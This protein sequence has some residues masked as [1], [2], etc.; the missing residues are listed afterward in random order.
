[1]LRPRRRRSLA[2]G[3]RSAWERH[4]TVGGPL[5]ERSRRPEG[6][7]LSVVGPNEQ[8]AT[9]CDHAR[10]IDVATRLEL[11]EER[12]RVC[13]RIDVVVLRPEIEPALRVFHGTAMNAKFRCARSSYRK[14]KPQVAVFGVERHEAR[15]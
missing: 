10:G 2:S 7:K 5:H 3:M 4:D 11:P 13:Q 14:L 8:E 12:A 9:G 6:I 15:R 1:M